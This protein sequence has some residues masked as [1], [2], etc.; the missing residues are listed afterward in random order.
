MNLAHR[1]LLAGMLAIVLCGTA[2]AH[3]RHDGGWTGGV[4]VTLAPRGDFYWHGGLGYSPVV[5]YPARQ[6]ARHRAYRVP[7]CHHPAHR[8]PVVYDRGHR[9]GRK[10]RVIH[11]YH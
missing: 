7:M 11:V 8:H 9:H 1:T 10:H 4:T 2:I 5:V 6:L 3:D